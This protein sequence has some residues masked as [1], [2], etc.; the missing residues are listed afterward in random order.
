MKTKKYLFRRRK[1]MLNESKKTIKIHKTKDNKISNKIV[2]GILSIPVNKGNDYDSCSVIS[3]TIVKSL[4]KKHIDIVYLKYD[5]KNILKT[6]ERVHGLVLPPETRLNRESENYSNA[7]KFYNICFDIYRHAKNMNDSGRYYPLL[8]VCR[9]FQNML[10]FERFNHK[11]RS[12]KY[13]KPCDDIKESLQYVNMTNKRYDIKLLPKM[14]KS[15]M[16]RN[17]HGSKNIPHNNNYGYDYDEIKNYKWF[18]KSFLPLSFSTNDSCTKVLNAIEST[19]YPFYAFQ[20]HPENHEQTSHL[21][22]FFGEMIIKNSTSNMSH[23]MKSC[24]DMNHIESNIFN[25]NEIKLLNKK[26][27]KTKYHYIVECV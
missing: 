26:F 2:I 18:K 13:Y 4:R 12:V 9:S 24:I 3:K 23:D 6:M 19:R 10:L 5:D 25:R 21:Y 20:F 1:Q 7:L 17:Y 22:D 11:I 14:N 15:E 8:G 16:F 27:D